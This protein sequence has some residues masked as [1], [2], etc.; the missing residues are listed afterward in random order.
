MNVYSSI[1]G[2]SLRPL[3][4][5][6]PADPSVKPKYDDFAVSATDIGAGNFS[7]VMKARHRVTGAVFALKVIEKA[8]IKRLSVRHK[9]MTNEV[10]MEKNALLRL[11]GHPNIVTLHHTFSDE[12]AVYYLYEMIDGGELWQQLMSEG[13]QVGADVAPIRFYFT[14]IIDALAHVHSHGLVHRWGRGVCVCQVT[15]AVVLVSCASVRCTVCV[16]FVCV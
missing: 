15:L 10:L 12:A 8:K 14:Q 2:R 6:A 7:R 4:H 16:C 9:N 13:V 11:R 3:P 1:A 5:A